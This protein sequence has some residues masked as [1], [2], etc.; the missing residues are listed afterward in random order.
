MT[1][2]QL[3]ILDLIIETHVGLKRQ[4][5][6]SPEATN[7]ALSFINDLKSISKTA[8]LGCGT[9]GQTMLLAQRL[10]G[11]VIGVDLIAEFIEVFNENARKLG[12]QD[13]LKGV[14]GDI[15]SLP[16]AQEELDLIWSEGVID[17]IGFEKGIAYWY[18]FLKKDG[19]I[20]LTCPS[21]LSDRKPAEIEEFW[22]DAVG[23]LDTIGHN[24]SVMKKT[25]FDL[26]GTFTLPEECWTCNYFAPRTEAEKALVMKYPGVRIVED[27]INANKYEVELYAKYSQYYG[28]VFYIGKKI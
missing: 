19:Y 4:G 18:G 8:D 5:P 16:F 1:D 7:K 13:R 2:Q 10:A 25:G 6:G 23:G 15:E 14:V 20:A 3:T 12:L 26:I 27:F 21:W 22:V 24:S 9:G 11:E 28:Y 17:N